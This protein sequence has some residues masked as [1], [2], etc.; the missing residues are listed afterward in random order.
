MDLIQQMNISRKNFVKKALKE[1]ISEELKLFND[2]VTLN[3]AWIY[4]SS[5]GL[6][7]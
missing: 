1:E 4:E 2:I 3:W 6:W 5:D 7:R